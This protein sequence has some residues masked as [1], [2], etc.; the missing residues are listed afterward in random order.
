MKMVLALI[1]LLLVL[2]LIS[3]TLGTA[4]DLVVEGGT[5]QEFHFEGIEICPEICP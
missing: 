4:S 2:L 1:L 3:L 5:I